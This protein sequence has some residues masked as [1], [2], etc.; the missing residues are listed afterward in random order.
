MHLTYLHVKTLITSLIIFSC[1]LSI[2]AQEQ[3]SYKFLKKISLPGDGKWDYLKMDGEAERLFVSHQDRVHIVDL[4]TD[5][6][7]G[8]ISGLKGVHGIALAKDLKKG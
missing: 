3:P 6:P 1:T 2:H 5:L 8:E 7:I 4:K